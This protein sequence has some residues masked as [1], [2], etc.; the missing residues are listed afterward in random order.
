MSTN[1]TLRGLLACPCGAACDIDTGPYATTNK[2]DLYLLD[3]VEPSCGWAITAPTA[4]QAL[5]AWNRRPLAEP[6]SGGVV[7]SG[8]QQRLHYL[9]EN[10]L[11]GKAASEVREIWR[12]VAALNGGAVAG[13]SPAAVLA[14]KGVSSRSLGAEF[15]AV[16]ADNLQDL[17]ITDDKPLPAVEAAEIE[18]DR[19]W[20]VPGEGFRKLDPKHYEDEPG[21]IAYEDFARILAGVNQQAGSG[22]IACADRLPSLDEPSRV[23]AK[24]TTC[25][26][27]VVSR[28]GC[29]TAEGDFAEGWS[30]RAVN[31]VS[32]SQ[33]EVTHWMP[34]PPSPAAKGG[35]A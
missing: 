25:G 7:L 19:Y 18:V 22:W 2:E 4:E 10:V 1:D 6:V 33:S 5:L 35:E 14:A 17:L 26:L 13:Q 34:L 32:F 9:C 30:W 16:L 8:I 3:C 20:H 27:M 31:D 28:G 12:D 11:R 24:T 29:L 15:A 23:L 21:Y